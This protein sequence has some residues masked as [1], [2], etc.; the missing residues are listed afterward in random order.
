V[1]EVLC[2]LFGEILGLA[3]VG[4]ETS[5]F[6]LGGDSLLAIRLVAGVRAFA[7]PNK[8]GVA[9][10][11]LHPTPRE[12]AELIGG[13]RA[14][15][16]P[17][18]HELTTAVAPE[19][20]VCSFVCVPYGGGSATV[21][22]PL[23]DALPAGHSLYAVGMPGHD[24]GVD[25]DPV[26]P[27]E[28]AGRCADE[29]LNRVDGP[30][31]LYGHCAIGSTL[32]AELAR[33]LEALGR[34]VEA[35]YVAGSF[36][37]AKPKGILGWIDALGDRLTGN[38]S[39]ANWLKSMGIDVDKIDPTQ[40]NRIVSN[41]RWDSRQATKH[42]GRMLEKGP[43]RLVAPVISVVGERDPQTEFYTERYREWGFLSDR[44]A[45]VVLDEA[46][47]YFLHHRAPELAN[48]ITRTHHDL[49]AA[50]PPEPTAPGPGPSGDRGQTPARDPSA[51][52]PSLGRF[53]VVATSQLVTVTGAAVTGWAIPVWVYT[54]TGSLG[55]LGLAGVTAVIPMLLTLPVAGTVAD[56]ADR[57][58]TIMVAVGC[59][60][61][62]SLTLATLLWRGQTALPLVYAATA[63]ITVAGT[64]QRIT[65]TAA[66]P[67]LAPKRYLGNA[68]GVTTLVN[69]AALLIAPLL[70]A[71]LLATVGLE[72]ILVIDASAGV[73][74]IGVLAV[75][76]FPNLLGVRRREPFLAEVLGGVRMC[77]RTSQLRAMLIFAS[78]GNLLYA[79]PV[80]LVAP[81]V[82][83]F[84]GLAQV[85][86][87]S[88]GEGLGA[89]VGGLLMGVWGG[90]RRRRMVFVLLA[91][92]AAGGF[93][94]F[95]GLRPNLMVVML[96]AVGSAL[97]LALSN[98]VYLT[99]IQVKFP[100]RFHGRV[101][102]LNQ[103][104]AWSTVPIAFAVLVPAS[105]ALN[106]L[107]VD[108]GAL[109]G[110]VGA[111]VGTGPGRGIGLA[112][113]LAGFALIALALAGLCMRILTR[114]DSDLPDALPDDV[115]GAGQRGS[116][117]A[118]S[119]L[120][121]RQWQG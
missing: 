13:D 45:L 43:A 33:R 90:P 34:R 65:F 91:I 70:A 16:R 6:D 94:A 108:G 88:F 59:A 93:V 14:G 49:A 105:G 112:Y 23:A 40:A 36:P 62:V 81:L 109:A 83:G 46:G 53:L 19:D 35:V 32:V 104:L 30:L 80:L 76:R 9:D 73:V 95:A 12:L 1:E 56:R 7:G 47:H 75:V 106:P 22:Q 11:Y 66:I 25:E 50:A 18:L 54:R 103:T 41:V 107:L 86:Q 77:W 3:R 115:V 60:G 99:I 79:V 92:A 89:L 8:V 29:I 42:M 58:R 15:S 100:Q 96:G 52:P 39:L 74:A 37:T 48:I 85:G 71:G 51:L 38:R 72:G 63:L 101:I 57:R 118:A 31:V 61:M 111:V 27:D 4:T 121:L 2:G 21:F 78:L 5:F 110:T 55:W 69:G 28:L 68:N 64:F 113:I 44:L 97:A 10:V 98:G 116:R 119:S 24:L 120:K 20:R 87:V 82:L 84:S 117:A 102:A 17:M 67:Q 114:L 26:T